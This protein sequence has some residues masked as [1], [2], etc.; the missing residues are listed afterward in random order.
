MYLP[1][2]IVHPVVTPSDCTRVTWIRYKRNNFWVFL[3]DTRDS[4]ISSGCIRTATMQEVVMTIMTINTTTIIIILTHII[5][6]KWLMISMGDPNQVAPFTISGV[7]VQVCQNRTSGASPENL[8]WVLRLKPQNIR[9]V[10]KS[11]L[12]AGLYNGL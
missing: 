7:M 12:L 2:K 8:L 6:S 10:W 9:K 5:W 1:V 4:M 3:Q 11:K